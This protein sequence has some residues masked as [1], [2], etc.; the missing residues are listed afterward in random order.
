MQTS[1][2]R[3]G[4]EVGPTQLL[5]WLRWLQLQLMPSWCCRSRLCRR[6]VAG[7]A[8]CVLSSGPLGPQVVAVQIDRDR[9]VVLCLRHMH[10][11]QRECAGAH[12]LCTVLRGVALQ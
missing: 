1:I 3:Y 2:L 10:V 8:C 12:V 4:T 11:E 7:Q 6:G 5:R 9:S